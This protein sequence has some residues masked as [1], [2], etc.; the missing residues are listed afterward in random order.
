M[1]EYIILLCLLAIVVEAVTELIIHSV[2]FEKVRLWLMAKSKFFKELLTCG[3]CTSFWVT[4][5]VWT[6]FA[7][8]DYMLTQCAPLIGDVITIFLIWRLSNFVDDFADK[9]LKL[10]FIEEAEFENPA[11][12]K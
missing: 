6:P 8:H 2:I 7:P 1:L 4:C 3:Y 12:E 5:A 10:F 11:S 9:Y